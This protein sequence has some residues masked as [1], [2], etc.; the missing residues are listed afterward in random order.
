ME[1]SK[2]EL[3]KITRRQVL[4]RA[5][6]MLVRE[7]GLTSGVLVK[8][9]LLERAPENRGQ[10]EVRILALKPRIEERDFADLEVE[11]PCE[12]LAKAKTVGEL[13]NVI[14]DRIPAGCRRIPG[15]TG[16]AR[17]AVGVSARKTRLSREDAY[18]R[19]VYMLVRLWG[20][21]KIPA[22]DTSLTDRY[23]KGLEKDSKDIS[24]LENPIERK[25]FADVHADVRGA[26]LE[27]AKTVR[28]LDEIIWKGI[29]E[30]YKKPDRTG[31]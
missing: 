14:W 10:K 28:K 18:M 8:D 12:E 1:K 16:T 19:T 27:C 17:S 7:W 5:K 9:S 20:L 29:P 3:R 6:K 4:N 15:K 22:P 26:V 25:D 11:I 31:P 21:Q 23:P 13:R 24:A 30:E 2:K